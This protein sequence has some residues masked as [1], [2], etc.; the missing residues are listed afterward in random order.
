MPNAKVQVQIDAL[1]EKLDALVG[2]ITTMAEQRKPDLPPKPIEPQVSPLTV[3]NLI[4]SAWQV[5][6]DEVLGKGFE[7]K[8]L[9]SSNGNYVMDV[10]MPEGLDRRVG[11]RQGRDHS[12]GLIRRASDVSDVETWCARIKEQIVKSYPN[13]V[14]IK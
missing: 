3:D 4:P 14:P 6:I 5:K 8:I 7:V 13:W 10:Y 9:E 12:T 1:S 11:E 2:V